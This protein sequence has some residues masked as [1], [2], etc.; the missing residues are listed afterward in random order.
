MPNSSQTLFLGFEQNVY[1]AFLP[2]LDSVT[3]KSKQESRGEDMQQ[4]GTG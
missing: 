2:V 3:V 4:K 1:L